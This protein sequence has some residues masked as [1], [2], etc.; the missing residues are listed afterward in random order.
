MFQLRS[1]IKEL[2]TLLAQ[3]ARPKIQGIL[4]VELRKLQTDYIN[5]DE[6]LK[7]QGNTAA[8]D[9]QN[10][11]DAAAATAKPT[12][13]SVKRGY[14]KEI[15]NYG[16]YWNTNVSLDTRSFSKLNCG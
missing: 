11:T 8:D 2:E 6:K 14:S 4:S 5:K 13:Q 1:D 7:K 16:K 9:S 3:A 15:S 10:G 12:V